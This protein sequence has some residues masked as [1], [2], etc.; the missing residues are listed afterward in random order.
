MDTKNRNISTLIS[1]INLAAA[2]LVISTIMLPFSIFQVVLYIFFISYA[3]DFLLDR[4]WKRLQWDKTQLLFIGFICFFSLI[5]IYHPF[6]NNNIYFV[7]LL[8]LRLPLLVFGVIGLFGYNSKYKLTYFAIALIVS[9]VFYIFYILF[10]IGIVDFVLSPDRAYLFTLKRIELVNTHMFFNFYLNTT[11][12]SGIYLFVKHKKKLHTAVKVALIVC[13]LLFYAILF[14][15]E[16]RSG[17]IASNLVLLGYFYWFIWRK[18]KTV[19]VTLSIA[20]LVLVLCIVFTH[21]R[22]DKEH[23]EEE[24]RLFL[25][26]VALDMISEKPLLGYGASRGEEVFM[27][28][29]TE[30]EEFYHYPPLEQAL[31][32]NLR[33]DSH[34]QYLQV[35]IEFGVIGLI[36]LCFI[37]IYPF[38]IMR[39]SKPILVCMFMALSMWQSFF[40]MFLT[41]QFSF[42]FAFIITIL[43]RVKGSDNQPLN[44]GRV[45][46]LTQ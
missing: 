19:A 26:E 5:L 45:S 31:N 27:Q 35:M 32:L 11:L 46:V 4:R 37:Y 20:S 12:I 44:E 8:E 38:F 28:K 9:S 43:F 36:L 3:V 24:P 21:P 40:D 15:S 10:S 2:L 6:E 22:V 23:L 7:R 18:N 17:F 42:I 13:L 1:Y 14:I 25:W 34:N 29:I 39:Q 33:I 30:S 16:G 41:G